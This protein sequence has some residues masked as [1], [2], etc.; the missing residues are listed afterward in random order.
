MSLS[1]VR[2]I[3]VSKFFC[4]SEPPGIWAAR[5]VVE[6]LPRFGAAVSMDWGKRKADRVRFDHKHAA[7]LLGVD[8]T[9]RRSCILVDIS[10]T[11]AKLQLDG[12]TDVLTAREFFLLLSTT[13]LAFRRCELVWIDGANVGVHFVRGSA[14]KRK[15]QS[16]TTNKSDQ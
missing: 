9:W 6:L 7:T 3:A 14:A 11:G 12:S 13:G 5:E 8:G 16:A 1:A 15:S 4:S 10:D 2:R